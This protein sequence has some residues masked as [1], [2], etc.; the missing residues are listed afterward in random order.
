MMRIKGFAQ[1]DIMNKPARV[2]MAGSVAAVEL[3]IAP[4][5]TTTTNAPHK[6]VAPPD[7]NTV[8]MRMVRMGKVVILAGVA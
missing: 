7:T 3:S 6:P 8:V 4:N 1:A 5:M 2:L